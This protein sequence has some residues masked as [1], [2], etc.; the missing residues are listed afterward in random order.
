M[1]PRSLTLR[2]FLMANRKR[3]P[4]RCSGQLNHNAPPQLVACF[5]TVM[6][7]GIV[8]RLV[9]RSE[10]ALHRCPR[11]VWSV[12]SCCRRRQHDSGIAELGVGF[13]GH[14]AGPLDSRAGWHRRGGRRPRC[15]AWSRR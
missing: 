9:C 13:Q 8:S 11:P 5:E 2:L 1:R 7:S 15:G 12:A 4:A 14:V 10:R 6:P 3:G